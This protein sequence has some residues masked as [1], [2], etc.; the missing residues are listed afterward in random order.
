MD[1][2]KVRHA[3]RSALSKDLSADVYTLRASFSAETTLGNF[4]I[5]RR[6]SVVQTFRCNY[7]WLEE[8]VF[9]LACRRITVTMVKLS[10]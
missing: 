8:H 10:A 2:Y 4:L 6:S 3:R 9:I 7:L 1:K 5:S